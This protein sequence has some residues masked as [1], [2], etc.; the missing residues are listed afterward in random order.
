MARDCCTSFR[1]LFLLAKKRAWTAE[2]E[3]SF[4]AL[5]QDARNQLVKEFAAEA[6]CIQ[7][8]DRIGTDGVTYTAFWVA[9][10]PS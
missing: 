9:D 1:D 2:E 5:D 3:R 6:G 10:R 8:E 4:Q 7:T